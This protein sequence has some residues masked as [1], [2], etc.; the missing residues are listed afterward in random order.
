MASWFRG[1][2]VKIRSRP[3]L[4]Y[5][6]STRTFLS[7]FLAIPELLFSGFTKVAVETQKEELEL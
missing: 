1:I 4:S 7:Q 5:F 2:N 3:M 6:C